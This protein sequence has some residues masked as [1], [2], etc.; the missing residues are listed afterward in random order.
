MCDY[1]KI[2]ENTE[3]S[4]EIRNEWFFKKALKKKWFLKQSTSNFRHSHLNI[5]FEPFNFN[6]LIM[7]SVS[8]SASTIIS[9]IQADFPNPKHCLDREERLHHA[10]RDAFMANDFDTAKQLLQHIG[11]FDREFSSKKLER[12]NLLSFVFGQMCERGDLDMC[13]RMLAEFPETDITRTSVEFGTYHKH[14]AWKKAWEHKH[15]HVLE[16]LIEVTGGKKSCYLNPV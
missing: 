10:V 15:F 3:M 6:P 12:I 5:S 7:T 16:W 1:L 9:K 2:R 8:A 4:D 13:K 14:Y 11:M